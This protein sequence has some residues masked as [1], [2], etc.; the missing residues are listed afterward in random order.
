MPVILV[1]KVVDNK[2]IIVVGDP[3]KH[4]TISPVYRRKFSQFFGGPVD[5]V[6]EAEDAEHEVGEVD[7]QQ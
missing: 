7:D 1:N 5:D 2:I 4:F 6:V 3:K